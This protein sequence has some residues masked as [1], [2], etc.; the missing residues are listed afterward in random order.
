MYPLV[1][2]KGMTAEKWHGYPR[3]QQI[4]SIA[5][6]LNRAQNSLLKDNLEY[7][8]HAWKRAF[9]LTDLTLEDNL[10]QGLLKEL[11]LFREMLGEVFIS[12][13]PIAHKKLINGL[14]T[15]D[16]AAYRM[17]HEAG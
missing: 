6:E 5:N 1:Y 10:P 4:L 8:E 9:E 16:A 17:L 12:H 7:A 11:L 13:D 14:I 3:F 2:Q 15:L